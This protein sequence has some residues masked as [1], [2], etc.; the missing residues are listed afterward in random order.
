MA[1]C[2]LLQPPDTVWPAEGRP[3]SVLSPDPR[4]ACPPALGPSLASQTGQPCER[5]ANCGPPGAAESRQS[6]YPSSLPHPGTLGWRLLTAPAPPQGAKPIR[7]ESGSP[8]P[9]RTHGS[10]RPGNRVPG[11]FSPFQS[12]GSLLGRGRGR[13]FRGTKSSSRASSLPPALAGSDLPKQRCFSPA[14]G[15]AAC[16]SDLRLFAFCSGPSW[17]ASP[18]STGPW[19]QTPYCFHRPN[20]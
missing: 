19:R 7:T 6:L 4:A 8:K 5:E 10:S 9:S 14:P 17:L 12:P 1:L 16:S 15:A 11:F 2:R 3:L 18:G 20:K 13:P